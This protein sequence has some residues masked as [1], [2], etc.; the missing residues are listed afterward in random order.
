M[1][2]VEGDWSAEEPFDELAMEAKSDA[3]DDFDVDQPRDRSEA[4][5]ESE[6]KRRRRRGRGRGRGRSR[7][8]EAKR[9]SVAPRDSAA[10]IDRI[11]D[12]LE[13]T[14]VDDDD[15]P[16]SRQ[17]RIRSE[18]GRDED[19]DEDGHELDK[20]HRTVPSW[21]EAIGLIV[22]VNLE[23]R[24]KSP[25]SRPANRGRG[26]GRSGRGRRDGNRP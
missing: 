12:A 4:T 18:E 6:T 13:F 24:A 1:E 15:E 2:P 10:P 11:D 7:P 16:I 25:G 8:D 21:E 14:E 3:V 23:A 26:R 17:S 22:S 9:E 20:S 19:A 5:E